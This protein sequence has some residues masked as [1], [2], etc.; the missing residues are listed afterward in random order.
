MAAMTATP[1][2]VRVGLRT[3]NFS[4]S[5]SS[6]SA[7]ERISALLG[8]VGSPRLEEASFFRDSRSASVLIWPFSIAST[9]HLSSDLS[10]N[11]SCHARSA[12]LIRYQ[13]DARDNKLL[14]NDTGATKRNIYVMRACY[15]PSEGSLRPP[16]SAGIRPI[17]PEMHH[18]SEHR[19]QPW[20]VR[21]AAQSAGR[22]C[23]AVGL[24][25]TCL[26]V[27]PA[28]LANHPAPL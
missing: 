25:R 19:L 6:G 5:R 7:S 3:S 28:P 9:M 4:D 24:I 23:T 16:P 12:S 26:P 15:E 14:G 8:R 13:I 2:R 21:I 22:D 27:E 11:W 17:I 20:L 10:A 1:E 18:S